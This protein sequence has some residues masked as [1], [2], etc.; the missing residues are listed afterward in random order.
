MNTIKLNGGL[1]YVEIYDPS[2]FNESEDARVA[3][4]TKV[5]SVC[6]QSD[7]EGKRSLYDKLYRESI[8]LPS[9]SFEFVPVVLR[10]EVHKRLRKLYNKY[11]KTVNLMHTL[12][13][14]N[15][16]DN[17]DGLFVAT[18]LRALM[19][20]VSEINDG[21]GSVNINDEMFFNKD[22]A[23]K[24]IIKDNFLFF[25]KKIDIVTAR[26]LMRH[27]VSWQEMSRRYVSNKKKPIEVYLSE[28]MTSAPII[29]HNGNLISSSDAIDI[30]LSLYNKAVEQGIK[31][32]EARRIVPVG[33]MTEVFS[34]WDKTQFD[35]MVTLRNSSKAQ[36]EIR[37]LAEA[38]SGLA[39]SIQ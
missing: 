30:C 34:M 15:I 11:A 33:M 38:M 28:K 20:D 29:E 12:K 24:Q 39:G 6:F 35:I 26:Q 16:L 4:V 9:T 7:M 37:Q 19:H 25:K 10:M 2:G 18:N 14:G 22:D 21:G 1:G 13:Y 23:T 5:A 32:Q 17:H 27:R 8:G 36:D 3:A 31:P